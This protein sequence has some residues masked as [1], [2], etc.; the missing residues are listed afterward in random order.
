VACSLEGKRGKS[1]DGETLDVRGS[2]QIRAGCLVFFQRVPKQRCIYSKSRSTARFSVWT[3]CWTR[4]PFS[5]WY[6]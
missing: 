3:G 5:I 6:H 4:F 1:Q 2:H